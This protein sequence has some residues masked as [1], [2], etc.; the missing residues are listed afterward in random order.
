V[1]HLATAAETLASIVVLA[2][3]VASAI[4]VLTSKKVQDFFRARGRTKV[5]DELAVAHELAHLLVQV[6]DGHEHGEAV[7]EAFLKAAKSPEAHDLLE[8][9]IAKVRGS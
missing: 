1:I 6:V 5:A 3:V 4:A 9:A 7:M 2:G 8:K